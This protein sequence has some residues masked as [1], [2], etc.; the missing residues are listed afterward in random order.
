M[1]CFQPYETSSGRKPVEDFLDTLSTQER[2]KIS[3]AVTFIQERWPRVTRPHIDFVE[4][5]ERIYE[6]RARHRNVNLR[7]LFWPHDETHILL[8]LHGFKKKENRVS[9][10]DINLA[11]QRKKDWV[12]R[13]AWK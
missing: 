4:P 11:I 9:R 2:S 1:W 7:V 5:E 13:G 6:L 12:R 8:A 3:V 10:E